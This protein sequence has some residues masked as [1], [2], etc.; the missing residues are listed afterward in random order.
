MRIQRKHPRLGFSKDELARAVTVTV[1][2]HL[3]T[4]QPRFAMQ[5]VQ[6]TDAAFPSAA[7]LGASLF[8]CASDL[9]L[10]ATAM[11]KRLPLLWGY[12]REER[13]MERIEQV[14]VGD[15]RPT[16]FARRPAHVETSTAWG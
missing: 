2:L 14:Q 4:D 9:A 11:T 16:G 12:P 7:H 6:T 8:V 3:D 10:G 5:P 13:G 1:L 15:I